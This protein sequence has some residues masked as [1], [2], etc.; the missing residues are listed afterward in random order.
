MSLGC[1]GCGSLITDVHEAGCRYANGGARPLP[2]II[3]HIRA[4]AANPSIK[5]TL[6]QTADLLAL[7]NAAEIAL[8]K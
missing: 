5:T 2:V 1:P 3:A 8:K 4:V 6:I 7:C